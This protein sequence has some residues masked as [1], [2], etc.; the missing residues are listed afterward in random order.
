M[1]A[2]A[3]IMTLVMC[4]TAAIY[5]NHSR[6]CSLPFEA[7]RLAALLRNRCLATN[8]NLFVFFPIA[9][10]VSNYLIINI[11]IQFYFFQV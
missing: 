3:D 7:R 5:F 9:F 10:P 8:L 2:E 11:N 4:V 1:R 6:A